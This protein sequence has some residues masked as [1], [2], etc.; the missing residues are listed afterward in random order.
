MTETSDPNDIAGRL[1]G[2]V[3]LTEFEAIARASMEPAAFDYVAGGAWDELSL[4]DNVAA[5]RRRRFRP[6]VLVDVS[7]VDPRSTFIGQPSAAPDRDRADG[8]PDAGPS[9]R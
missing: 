8:V 2:V 9:G 1:A 5:W 7:A 4:H 3:N 6:R